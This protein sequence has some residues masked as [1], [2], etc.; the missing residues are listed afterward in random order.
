MKKKRQ[1]FGTDGVRG[2]AGQY[3]LDPSTV[4]KIGYAAAQVFKKHMTSEFDPVIILG[5]DT[6]QSGPSIRTSLIAG[7]SHGGLTVVDCDIITTPGI[8]YM[9]KTSRA[10]AGV[11]ISASHNPYEDNGIKF[12]SHAGTKLPDEI[13]LEI[14]D[15]LSDVAQPSQ[16][17]REDGKH[18]VSRY[19]SFLASTVGGTEPLRGMR[20]VVDCGNGAAVA[21]APLLFKELGADVIIVNNQPTGKNINEKCGALYPENISAQ[22]VSHHAA[23][24]VSYDGDADRVMFIDETGVVRDGDYLLAIMAIHLKKTGRLVNN[25]LVSTVMANL[26]LVRAMEREGIV[27]KQT[28]VGDRYVYEE[29]IKTGA[30]IGGEQSG[31]IILTDFLQTGDGIL[32]SLQILSI[33]KSAGKP[34]S[35]L[36]QTMQKY[37]QVLINARVAHKLP[38]EQLPHTQKA[39]SEAQQELAHEGRVLV[40]YSGTENLLRVM[41]EGKDKSHINAMAQNI[42]DIA[43]TELGKA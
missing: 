34:F 39:M 6:R 3:P 13:E 11:V 33:L 35:E 42:V 14:E 5:M 27:V 26:G 19:I 22:V 29:M 30:I 31:H 1:L 36:A 15:A 18:L 4:T 21:V 16:I 37:P 28:A 12:F 43:L 17:K 23:C 8:A 10:V 9:T 38:I 25:T 20:I 2:K 7:L 32:S 24:G 41:I 40:R